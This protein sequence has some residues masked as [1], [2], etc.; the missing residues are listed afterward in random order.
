[1]SEPIP[2]AEQ[3][4]GDEG[5]LARRL[6]Q[7][8]AGGDRA[9]FQ[10]FYTL[11]A[12]RVLAMVR[13]KSIPALVAEE[14]VQDVF[15]AAWLSA[16]AYRPELGEPD[17]WLSGIVRH[18]LVDHRR[19]MRRI[20]AAIGVVVDVD[21]RG[22][23]PMVDV[24]LA[25][26]EALGRLTAE[27]RRLLDLI[28]RQGFTFREAARIVRIPAGTVKSRVSAALASMRASLPGTAGR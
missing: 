19:R 21:A 8:I 11:Y 1:M 28:Y 5:V 24:R 26:E 15:V 2:P 25:L 14:L 3:N 12:G 16:S 23:L 9:A 10:A 13:R 22:P 17:R 4:P 27:Q 18:K 7:G 20:A 6:L